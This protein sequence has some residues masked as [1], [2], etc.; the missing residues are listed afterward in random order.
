MKI[1]KWNDINFYALKQAVDKTHRTLHKQ[2]KAFQSVLARPVISVLTDTK[3]DWT[4]QNEA[5]DG[6]NIT[7]EESETRDIETFL[8][9]KNLEAS[10]YVF[11]RSSFTYRT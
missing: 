8:A 11:L 7:G 2:V 10:S 6:L 3:S 5:A 4:T 9:E 1:A